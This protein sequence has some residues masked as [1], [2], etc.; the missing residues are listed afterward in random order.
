MFTFQRV[1]Q[2]CGAACILAA[3]CVHSV[4][5]RAQETTPDASTVLELDVTGETKVRAE[6]FHIAV[7]MR[8]NGVGG[9]AVEEEAHKKTEQLSQAAKNAG[10]LQVR[11]A[12]EF[13]GIPSGGD[14][15]SITPIAPGVAGVMQF[16]ME[17]DAHT[18]ADAYRIVKAWLPLATSGRL[19]V[20]ATAQNAA[21]SYD[22]ALKDAVNR[23]TT[24]VAVLGN[25]AKPK[26]LT[27]QKLEVGD[28]DDSGPIYSIG[29]DSLVNP[30]AEYVTARLPVKARYSLTEAPPAAPKPS[31]VSVPKKPTTKRAAKS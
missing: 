5:V 19:S 24:R 23:L 30:I 28:Y 18:S 15:I 8:V 12:R 26:R 10:A 11:R 29:A 16:E 20:T 14:S 27:L 17:A 7:M 3:F 4:P 13:A 25:A 6:A 2:Y 22:T 9:A 31:T 21:S 1:K